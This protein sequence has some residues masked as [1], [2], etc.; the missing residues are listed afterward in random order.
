MRKEDTE[1]LY[2]VPRLFNKLLGTW[3]DLELELKIALFLYSHS[4]LFTDL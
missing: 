1:M 3:Q 4:Q 2:I